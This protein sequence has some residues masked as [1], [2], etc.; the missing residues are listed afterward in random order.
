[1]IGE[2][3]DFRS[4]VGLL[5]LAFDTAAHALPEEKQKDEIA[6][7]DFFAA[8]YRFNSLLNY[9]DLAVLEYGVLALTVAICRRTKETPRSF[10]ERRFESAPTDT[11]WRERGL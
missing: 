11:W 2:T 5:G 8:S 3:N 1:M 10:F 4:G 6:D 7:E 9:A